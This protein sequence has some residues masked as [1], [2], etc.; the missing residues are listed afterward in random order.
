MVIVMRKLVSWVQGFVLI[1]ILVGVS[2]NVSALDNVASA[3]IDY[4]T[5]PSGDGASQPTLSPAL[6]VPI[7]T[8]S[9]SPP[10]PVET[11]PISQGTTTNPSPIIPVP[12]QTTPEPTVEPGVTTDGIYTPEPAKPE[13]T[14]SPTPLVIQLEKT[15]CPDCQE[16]NE[17][18]VMA[19]VTNTSASSEPVSDALNEIQHAI[20]TSQKTWTAKE[21]EISALSDEEFR[22]MLGVIPASSAATPLPDIHRDPR[23]LSVRFCSRTQWT[24]GTIMATIRPR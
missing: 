11:V 15:A 20:K 6:T 19:A 21:N 16:D 7:L 1:L 18:A 8:I 22:N 2:S 24:G 23:T 9:P 3:P 5:L 14:L 13:M 10:G 12:D 4:S 17:G